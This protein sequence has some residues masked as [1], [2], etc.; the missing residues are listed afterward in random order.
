MME[1]RHSQKFAVMM[2]VQANGTGCLYLQHEHMERIPDF[3][4]QSSSLLSGF[5]GDK[6]SPCQV[7]TFYRC[8]GGGGQYDWATWRHNMRS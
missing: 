8:V 4:G 6:D 3:F 1:A 2:P 7:C 5:S